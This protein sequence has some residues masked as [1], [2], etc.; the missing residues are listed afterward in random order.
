[1]ARLAR[2]NFP[3]CDGFR[4]P[5]SVL[6]EPSVLGRHPKPVTCLHRE[7]GLTV[8][9]VPGRLADMLVTGKSVSAL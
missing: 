1:M 2:Y 9:P 6:V 4:T 8:R 5:P 7:V 3:F